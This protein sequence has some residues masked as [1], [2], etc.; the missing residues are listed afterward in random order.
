MIAL[1]V[2]LRDGEM[3]QSDSPRASLGVVWASLLLSPLDDLTSGADTNL[4]WATGGASQLG[5][6]FDELIFDEE[7]NLGS[8]D[9]GGPRRL[10][11]T[12]STKCGKGLKAPG[13]R[14][15]SAKLS[16]SM[17]TLF[18][19]QALQALKYSRVVMRFEA[20]KM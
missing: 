18:F 13:A 2:S 5:E 17:M 12:Q 8:F 19:S 9:R 6:T 16:W 7:G 4:C 11:M 15:K 1:T 3:A 20:I 10:K 14:I